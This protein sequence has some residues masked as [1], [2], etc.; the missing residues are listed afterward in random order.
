MKSIPSRRDS[1]ATGPAAD[2]RRPYRTNESGAA[3]G[4]LQPRTAL[5]LL[6]RVPTCLSRQLERSSGVL[7]PFSHRRGP[8]SVLLLC[9]VVAR[10]PLATL[11]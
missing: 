6:R 3:R 11:L 1:W 4:A 9:V 2:F 7:P 8:A 10:R 5:K